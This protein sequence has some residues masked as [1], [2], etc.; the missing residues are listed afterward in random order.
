MKNFNF[1][2]CH[3]VKLFNINIQYFYNQYMIKILHPFYFIIQKIYYR[4]IRQLCGFIKG[5]FRLISIYLFIICLWDLLL[6]GTPMEPTLGYIPL[7]INTNCRM[8]FGW[9]LVFPQDQYCSVAQSCLTLCNLMNRSTP[10]LP[11]HH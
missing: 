10:G 9:I 8:V 11:V 1:L 4:T 3:F 2:K 5:I 6:Y 7:T